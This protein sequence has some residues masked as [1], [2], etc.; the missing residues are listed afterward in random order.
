MKIKLIIIDYNSKKNVIQKFK[1]LLKNQFF[2]SEIKNL[3]INFYKKKIKNINQEGKKVTDNQISNM[4]N[5]N[6]S[7]NLS[8]NCDDLI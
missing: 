6:Q 8:K 2:K 4:S 5:I 7:L 1:K 3:D